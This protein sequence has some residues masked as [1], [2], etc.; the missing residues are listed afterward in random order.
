MSVDETVWCCSQNGAY[1]FSSTFRY[2]EI[3]RRGVEKN[4]GH[5]NIQD[6][7]LKINLNELA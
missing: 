3:C 5:V 6:M 4:L 7:Y 1:Y 2:L